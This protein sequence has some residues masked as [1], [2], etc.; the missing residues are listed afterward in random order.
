M[1]TIN[2]REEVEE[3][4]RSCPPVDSWSSSD[5]LT[6]RYHFISTRKV[7]NFLNNNG[8]TPRQAF[9]VQGRDSSTDPLHKKHCVR[10][11]NLQYAPNKEDGLGGLAPE[12]IVTN[13]HDG[14]SSLRLHAGLFRL[15]CSNGLT[16]T[17]ETY[18]DV[19]I[20][21]DNGHLRAL[22]DIYLRSV[23]RQFAS[24]V[25]SGMATAKGWN[26]MDM[27]YASRLTYYKDAGRLRNMDMYDYR[28]RTFDRAQRSSDEGQDLWTVYN[29][30]QE[31]LTKGGIINYYDFN[32]GSKIIGR[33]MSP[34]TSA[35]R[36]ESVNRDLWDLTLQA[37]ESLN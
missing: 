27:D 34:L 4:L 29:R 35:E 22:G 19:R 12:I 3:V 20:R 5:D 6:D 11:T 30:T 1:Q 33:E 8:W 21:H 10:F 23:L 28:Y 17:E 16:I 36:I 31:Y 2:T 24:G 25:P 15:V 37:A 14:S 32:P 9:Y 13:S 26:E 18:G 7:S